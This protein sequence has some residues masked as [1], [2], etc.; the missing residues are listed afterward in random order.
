MIQK[1]WGNFEIIA[2]GN[3][4]QVKRLTIRPGQAIS[5]QKHEY[6]SEVWQVVHG[7]GEVQVGE[8][9]MLVDSLVDPSSG[10]ISIGVMELHRIRNVGSVDLVVIE[11]QQGSVI[12][13]DD[14]I[15]YADDYGRNTIRL[16]AGRS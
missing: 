15:R 7:Q 10:P 2:G 9:F 12:M 5:L 1:P 14:V 4:Y 13:E 8:L 16:D 3:A 11:I 6:R